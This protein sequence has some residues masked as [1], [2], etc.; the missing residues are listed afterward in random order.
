MRARLLVLAAVL[1]VVAIQVWRDSGR[2]V[3]PVDAERG[4]PQ[5]IAQR[6]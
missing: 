2:A 1:A 3:A 5:A 4:R 6:M